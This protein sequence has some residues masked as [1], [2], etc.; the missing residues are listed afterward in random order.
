[1]SEDTPDQGKD[2]PL[3]Y[4]HTLKYPIAGVKDPITEIVFTRRIIARDLKGIP[5]G[6]DMTME[7]MTALIARVVGKPTAVIELI[8][9]VDLVALSEVVA[10]FLPN[11]PKTGPD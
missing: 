9:A 3:P 5:A 1:M 10:S 4:T 11:S 2:F 8:D 6:K 7:H